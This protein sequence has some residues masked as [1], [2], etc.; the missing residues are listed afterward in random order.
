MFTKSKNIEGEISTLT[1]TVITTKNKLNKLDRNIYLASKTF[2][3]NIG[4]KILK[5]FYKK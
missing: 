2:P 5:K 3:L 1:D 4:V